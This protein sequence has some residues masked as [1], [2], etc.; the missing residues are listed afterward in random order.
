MDWGSVL[1][2]LGTGI[3]GAVAGAYLRQYLKGTPPAPQS[4][5]DAVDTKVDAKRKDAPK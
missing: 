1:L 3:A 4:S 2:G 5:W